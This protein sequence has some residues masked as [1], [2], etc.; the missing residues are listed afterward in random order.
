MAL[1]KWKRDNALQKAAEA[2]GLTVI[3]VVP[4][5]LARRFKLLKGFP[6]DTFGI[7]D[8][9][10]VAQGQYKGFPVFAM[11]WVTTEAPSQE[12]Q[13]LLRSKK[14][15]MHRYGAVVVCLPFDAPETVMRKRAPNGGVEPIFGGSKAKAY[16][17]DDKEFAWRYRVQTDSK[18]FV[19]ELL[20]PAFRKMML[21]E[22]SFSIEL[23]RDSLCIRRAAR[24]KPAEYQT[25]LD[26]AVQ[27]AAALPLKYLDAEVSIDQLR[28]RLIDI[29][30]DVV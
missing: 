10:I 30:L 4:A 29:S 21:D 13:G 2:T 23:Q 25:A 18:E 16:E 7:P 14:P 12:N 8:G 24:F 22:D 27:L 11:D 19:D 26:F 20:R 6:L 5:D 17:Y 3:P 15:R 9:S 1:L 28:R